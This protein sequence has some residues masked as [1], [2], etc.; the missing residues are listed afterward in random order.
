MEENEKMA[1]NTHVNA[2]GLK[3]SPKRK[4]N[5]LLHRYLYDEYQNIYFKM[6]LNLYFF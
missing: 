6:I 2:N 3:I 4:Q 1:V 5:I